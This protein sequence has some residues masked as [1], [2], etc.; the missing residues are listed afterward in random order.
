VLHS[1]AIR[2]LG[3]AALL[4]LGGAAVAVPDLDSLVHMASLVVVGRV[5]AAGTPGTVA[6]SNPGEVSQPKTTY[7]VAIERVVRGQSAAST[8]NVTQFGNPIRGA[9]PGPDDQPLQA[10]QRY[11]L[12]LQ[13]IPDGTY[14]TVSGV[15]GR[16]SVDNANN[17]HLVGS[18]SPATRAYEAQPLDALLNQVAGIT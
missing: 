6:P 9:P 2:Q 11:V 3:V 17:I 7:P 18:G 12:F 15:Q 5:V 13:Q 16:L 4:A 1:Q 14:V 10:G 8:V